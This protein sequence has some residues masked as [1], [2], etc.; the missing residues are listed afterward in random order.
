MKEHKMPIQLSKYAHFIVGSSRDVLKIST[1][2]ESDN[3]N[4]SYI[5][6]NL[7]INIQDEQ[8]FASLNIGEIKKIFPANINLNSDLNL[9]IFL[10]FPTSIIYEQKFQT[11]ETRFELSNQ[12]TELNTYLQK[13]SFSDD[14]EFCPLK[15]KDE[16]EFYYSYFLSQLKEHEENIILNSSNFTAK[17]NKIGGYNPTNI[18]LYQNEIFD[19]SNPILP[20]FSINNQL[21]DSP[22]YV[23]LTCFAKKDFLTNNLNSKI[24]SFISYY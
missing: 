10:S 19:F 17:E 3:S 12:E 13:I 15:S 5:N 2:E 9:N 8:L 20:L 14:Y 24:I 4:S 7:N 22:Q 11:I 18:D 23:S 21:I 1:E 6:K 16:C